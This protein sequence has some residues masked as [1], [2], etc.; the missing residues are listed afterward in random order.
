MSQILIQQYLNQLQDLRKVSGTHRESVVR[1]AFKD[2][3]K[4]WARSHDLVFVPEYEI[5][6]KAKDRRY[7]D[8]ALLYELR[9]PFGYWE[10]K[11][12]KDDLDAEIE[13]KFRRG[14]PQDNI[15]FEDSTEAVL[16]Q[17]RQEV[18]RCGVDDVAAL[19]KLLGLFFGYERVEIAEF[20]KAVEQFKADLPAVLE[21]LRNMIARAYAE[22]AAFRKASEKFLAHAQE[23]INPSLADADVRE[24]LI[25]HVLTEEIFSKV[26]GEDDFHQHNNVAK[27]LYALEETFFT[28]DLK[29]R[30]LRGLG[31]YYAAIRAAAAQIGS[32]HEKQAFLKVIYENFYKVYNVKAADR[33]GV[34]YTPNEIV[35]FMVESADWLCE[36][37]F[38]RNLIDKDVEILDPAVGTGT[39]ICE[40]LEHFRGQKAKLRH[41]YLEEL[42]ANEVAILPYYV[43]NLNIE[44]TYAAITGDYL[45]YPNLCFV[46]TLDNVGLHTAAHGS[47]ADLFGSVS[48]QNLARIK[49]QNSRKISVIIG[50]PP[51]N[52]NQANENDNNKNREYPEIDQ[53]IKNTY[54]AES[55]AQK[56]KLYDM[57]ARFFRWASDRLDANGIL[58]FISNRSF[59]E[60]RTFDGFR[61]VVAQEFNDIYVVDLGGDVRANPKLS[62]TKHNVFGIQTGVAISFMVKRARQGKH[63]EGCRIYYARRPE[64]ETAEE[65]LEFLS[66]A[67][68]RELTFDEIRPDAK[69]YW[70]DLTSNDFDTLIPIASRAVKQSKG[71]AQQRAIFRLYS[72][73]L[74]TNR[75]DW[76]CDFSSQE[77]I[78]RTQHLISAY[79]AQL[80]TFGVG[81]TRSN[82]ADRVK[83]NIK[84]TRKLKSL[85]LAGRKLEFNGAF[86]VESLY[87]P[88]TKNF[89][90]FSSE[91]NEDLYQ[92][93]RFFPRR[94]RSNSYLSFIT[95]TRLDFG[96]LAG[97]DLPNYGLYSLDPA[98]FVPFRIF[99]R[100]GYEDNITDWALDQFKK[101][102]QPG[103]AKPKRPIIKEA[104]FHY[105][106]GVLHDPVYR[107]KYAQNLKREFPRIPFYA[108]FWQWADWGKTLMDLHIGYETVEP[109]KLER[110]EAGPSPQLSPRKRGEGASERAEAPKPM[111]KVDREAGRIVLD[112]QTA[113]AGIPPEAWDYKLGN[114]SALEWILD[115]Y[116]EKKPKDPTIREK[117][118]TYR[119][120]DYKEKVIDLLMRVTRV[121]V[122]TQAVVEAMG[123][124]AR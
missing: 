29:K 96:V 110:I 73:G 121:S 1:E 111:L 113:L 50:N 94:D 77:V 28:G 16:I 70:L 76:V 22:N 6:T 14:Y 41:K 17:N 52:A 30:T 75:D 118:D 10:A 85:A 37:H 105:V 106:Y 63:V 5:E 12:E 39:F 31:S 55:T 72:Q 15:V 78:R 25:Q 62:G 102:Y 89:T 90:Y 23:A 34:V 107:K 124:A 43:A 21:S 95:G 74:K 69:H 61:K 19:E 36:K 54:I 18:M 93:E 9:M 45:E 117:F 116:K 35:R 53:R 83:Y 24:M 60:S 112:T 59:I 32:H 2:L 86:V 44:A 71:S 3:L 84:W 104:I 123:K 56:T 33:L 65:K 81:V 88:F 58:A 26:F 46:D 82:I 99:G 92:L 79:N 67:R 91:L 101:Q 120:A 80:S 108:D 48:E 109:F 64:L 98:Q 122:E 100:E 13:Y 20:R 119:F 40:L 115:Q 47:T 7:V 4:G 49:R 8:G 42:H 57:Y 38:G 103:R 87:R 68:M 114:R 11:D 66:S 51:Y 27:E 97:C